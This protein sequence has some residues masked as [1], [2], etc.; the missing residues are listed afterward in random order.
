MLDQN[1]RRKLQQEATKRAREILDNTPEVKG[2][3]DTR[4]GRG[5][6]SPRLRPPVPAC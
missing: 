3:I 2:G 4:Y 6:P 1:A 5:G